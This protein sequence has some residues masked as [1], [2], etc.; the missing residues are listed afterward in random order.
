[1]KRNWILCF[2]LLG[3]VLVFGSPSYDSQLSKLRSDVKTAMDNAANLTGQQRQI[4]SD[5]R[6][7]LR[8]TTGKR[9]IRTA[10]DNIRFIANADAFRPHDKQTVLD[11]LKHLREYRMMD[12][13]LAQ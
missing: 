8:E 13:G 7:T 12:S 1:M 9:E 11:D 10:M 5:A 6:E 2:A 3:A 4:L